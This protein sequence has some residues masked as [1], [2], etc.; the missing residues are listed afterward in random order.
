VDEASSSCVYYKKKGETFGSRFQFCF[1]GDLLR[2][3]NA[4]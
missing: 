3:T 2:S 4:Y 1:D